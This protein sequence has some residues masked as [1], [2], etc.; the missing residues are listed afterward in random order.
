MG[1][2]AA[3]DTPA[4]APVTSL[5]IPIVRVLVAEPA[6]DV[7][8][9]DGELTVVAEPALEV[10]GVVAVVDGFDDELQ[11]AA[12]ATN[13]AAVKPPNA[14]LGKNHLIIEPPREAVLNR[15]YHAIQFSLSSRFRPKPSPGPG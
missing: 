3:P 2:N 10:G 13:S 12:P 8:T 6:G 1:Y 5:M 15:L 14:V 7:D 4:R 11:A 9:E